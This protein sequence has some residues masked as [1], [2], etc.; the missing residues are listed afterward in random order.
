MTVTPPTKSSQ[1]QANIKIIWGIFETEIP[2]PPTWRFRL[3][4]SGVEPRDAESLKAPEED[5]S[6][7]PVVKN[8]LANARDTGS[9]PGPGRYHMLQSN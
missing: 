6:G 3:N 4:R 5:F 1:S 2:R 7:D 8:L 9:I